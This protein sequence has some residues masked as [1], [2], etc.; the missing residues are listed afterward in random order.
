ML[1]YLLNGRWV[2]E[3]YVYSLL[4]LQ[5]KLLWR[6]CVQGHVII[7]KIQLHFMFITDLSTIAWDLNPGPLQEQSMLLT[8]ELSPFV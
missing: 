2:F 4:L 6:V 3:T 1:I 5:I 7:S 8:T